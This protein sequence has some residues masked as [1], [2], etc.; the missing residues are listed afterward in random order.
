M[1]NILNFPQPDRFQD[2]EVGEFTFPIEVKYGISLKCCQ[3]KL[4][5]S[6]SGKV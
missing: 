6:I 5:R 2:T 3:G 1:R 4:L